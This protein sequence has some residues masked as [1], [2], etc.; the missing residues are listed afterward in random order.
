M[1]D[2]LLRNSL[3]PNKVIKCTITFRQVANKQ[4]N[5]DAVWLIEIGTI[6]PDKDGKAIKPIFI[7]TTPSMNIDAA[8]KKATEEIAKQV[9]WGTLLVDL[10]PP[11]VTHFSPGAKEK[12]V[13]INSNVVID[14][15]DILP[16]AGINPDSIEV[17]V[18]DIDVSEEISIDGDPYEYRVRWGPKIRVYDYE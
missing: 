11:F 18:N 8:I 17:I 7:H 13:S 16:A 5:G 4:N 1:V 15:K 3:N 2:Y 12:I 9:N 10:R 6:E 14:I